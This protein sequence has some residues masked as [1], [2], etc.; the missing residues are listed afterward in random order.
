MQEL[1]ACSLCDPGTVTCSSECRVCQAKT[2]AP[3]TSSADC[4]VI[5]MDSAEK[6]GQ[7]SSVWVI[8]WCCKWPLFCSWAEAQVRDLAPIPVVFGETAPRPPCVLALPFPRERC[9]ATHEKSPGAT[10]E[11]IYSF[12][13]AAWLVGS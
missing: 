4:P 5:E 10:L 7:P 8:V 12:G 6:P 1:W 2:V 3:P 11:F 9:R 13:H